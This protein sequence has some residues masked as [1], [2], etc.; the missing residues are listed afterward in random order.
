MKKILSIILAI[1]VFM[2]I[3]ATTV[4][5]A[6]TEKAVSL[7]VDLM[8]ET[9]QIPADAGAVFQD[10]NGII[11]IPLRA[12]MEACGYTVTWVSATEGIVVQG[13]N[14]G[15]VRYHINSSNITVDQTLQNMDA[16]A[17]LLNEITYIP[18]TS[19][20]MLQH[21]TF[22]GYFDTLDSVTIYAVQ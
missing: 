5:A 16:P 6:D 3:S 1:T 4:F 13:V 18:L 2:S 12:V 15:T 9:K 21:Q 17:L 11:Y 22:A 10:A 14:V 19:M 20:N 8:T 7:Y